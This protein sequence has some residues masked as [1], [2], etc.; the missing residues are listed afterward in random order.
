MGIRKE[1]ELN[2]FIRKGVRSAT[3]YINE[4]RCSVVAIDYMELV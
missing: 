4:P 2:G 1:E 3:Y